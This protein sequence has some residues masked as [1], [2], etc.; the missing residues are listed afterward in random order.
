L[1]PSPFGSFMA[2]IKEQPFWLKDEFKYFKTNSV[3][4]ISESIKNK[5][6]AQKLNILIKYI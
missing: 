1:W 6:D 3:Y 4:K 2:M 5:K